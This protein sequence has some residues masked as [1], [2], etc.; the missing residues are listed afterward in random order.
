MLAIKCGDTWNHAHADAAHFILY[1][2]GEDQIY[3]AMTLSYSD[4]LYLKY[5]V[6][7]EAH[8]VLKF[9][10]KG[11][12]YRDNYKNH[13]KLPGKL[14]NY[15]DEAGFRYIVA[16]GTGPMSR[17]FRKHHR[18]FLWLDGFIL[19][20]D[21]VE[22]YENG[23]VNFLLHAKEENPFVMLTP[24]TVTEHDGYVGREKRPIQ[25]KSYNRMTDDEGHVKFVSLLVLDETLHPVMT[26]LD[27]AWKIT[28]G[29]TNVYINRLS[30]GKIMHRNCINVMDGITTDAIILVDKQGKYGVVNG[31]IVRKDGVSYHDT[32]ARTNGWV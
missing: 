26:E 6:Q 19:I 1:R 15:V 21:D 16:D 24:C 10:G 2:K 7:S 14:C 8:N 12:D 28:C 11:Q 29:D 32:W 30:D 3:D 20:Y 27:N 5:Y 22:C 31:S 4:P 23:E 17:W 9:E 18:H 25:Y 13:A